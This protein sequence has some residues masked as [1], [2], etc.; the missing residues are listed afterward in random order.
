MNK[1]GDASFLLGLVL[2]LALG[3]AVALIL[4]ESME[5]PGDRLESG[6]QRA[7]DKLESTAE[8]TKARVEGAAEGAAQP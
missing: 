4:N 8:D 7:A 5:S 1:G 3:A 2:G 6:F